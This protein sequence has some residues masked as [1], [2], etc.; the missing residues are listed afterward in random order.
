MPSISYLKNSLKR[1][2]LRFVNLC[3]QFALR[4]FRDNTFPRL[5]YTFSNHLILMI[6]TFTA[7][8]MDLNEQY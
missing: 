1:Y 5:V 3:L 8:Q 7:R 2:I 6:D 4:L